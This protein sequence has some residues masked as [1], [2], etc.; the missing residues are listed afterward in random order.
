MRA[1]L[2]LG[3]W[4]PAVEACANQLQAKIRRMNLRDCNSAPSRYR[5]VANHGR[6]VEWLRE[7]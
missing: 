3:P 6:L 4:A 2:E 7:R 1:H 5:A